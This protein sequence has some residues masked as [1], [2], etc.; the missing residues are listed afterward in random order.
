MGW[1]RSQLK[2]HLFFFLIPPPKAG[3]APSAITREGAASE[4]P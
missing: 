3:S 1:E 2:I 4:S